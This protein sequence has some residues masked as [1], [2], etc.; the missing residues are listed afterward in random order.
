MTLRRVL[1]VLAHEGQ[2]SREQVRAAL[3]PKGL[4]KLLA[5]RALDSY[6]RAL[7]RRVRRKA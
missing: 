5:S 2:L 3:R 6:D 4:D 7:L 1:T